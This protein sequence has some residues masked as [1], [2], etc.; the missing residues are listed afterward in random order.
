VV[1]E[2]GRRRRAYVII[3]D[4]SG[5]MKGSKAVAAAVAAAALLLNLPPGDEGGIVTFADAA[6]IILPMGAP[7]AWDEV[8]STILDINPDGCTDITAALEVGLTQLALSHAKDKIGVVVTDGW[9]NVGPD[10]VP[11]ATKF[12][13][14]HILTLPGG[15]ANLCRQMAQAGRSQAVPVRDLMDLP[16]ALRSCLN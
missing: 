9:A 10:P 3:L 6:R 14:L 12:S 7:V 16:H 1:L 4:E 15:D 13:H 5:S 8:I 2:P 11:L